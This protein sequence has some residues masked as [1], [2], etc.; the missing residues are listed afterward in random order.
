MNNKLMEFEK[1]DKDQNC[2][3][4]LMANLLIQDTSKKDF[5]IQQDQLTTLFVKQ[6][7][8]LSFAN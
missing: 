8:H 1:S 5:K 3:N 6:V 4:I 2:E 7:Q